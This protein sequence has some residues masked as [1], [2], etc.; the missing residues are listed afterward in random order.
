MG[1]HHMHA[2]VPTPTGVT[3]S[4][5]VSVYVLN[6]PNSEPY[7]YPHRPR[8]EIIRPFLLVPL[9][10]AEKLEASKRGALAFPGFPMT[11]T[12]NHMRPRQPTTEILTSLTIP[13][14][15][16]SAP[17][18]TSHPQTRPST[19]TAKARSPHP[20]SPILSSPHH[21][22]PLLLRSRRRAGNSPFL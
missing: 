20:A 15:P 14:K 17:R 9:N 12:R 21:G 1:R 8:G 11:L 7:N 4:N 18:P 16:R 22:R 2:A 13:D 6:N 3:D 19:T 5:S 10:R